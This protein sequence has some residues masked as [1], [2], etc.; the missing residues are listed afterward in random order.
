MTII[1]SLLLLGVAQG[2]LLG[3]VLWTTKRD[4][5][6]ANRMLGSVILIFSF[7]ILLHAL[8]HGRSS[9]DLKY[10]DSILHLGFLVI[11]PLLF[12][13]I[14]ALTAQS[15][16]WT[17]REFLHF[18]PVV[19]G[20]ALLALNMPFNFMNYQLLTELI[21]ASIGV[22]AVFY[23][24]LS[25]LRLRRHSQMI[26]NTFSSIEKINLRWIRFLLGMFC[27]AWIF[28]FAMEISKNE[29]FKIDLFWLFMSLFIYLMGYFGLRQPEIFTGISV[30]DQPLEPADKPKYE[31]ST[32]TFQKSEEY[33]Q[34]LQQLMKMEK[35]YIERDI[36]LPIL[37]EKMALTT[38][39]LSQIINE[40]LNKNFFEFINSYRIEEAKTMMAD[41]R[42]D[43]LSIA[44]LAYDAGFNSISAFN[45]A[46][47]KHVGVTPSQ[48]RQTCL[49]HL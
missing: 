3:I 27:L 13:Y 4:P 5:K 18:I 24:I 20:F 40:R 25:Y 1:Q 37:A 30:L 44:G 41:R 48:F 43:H 7:S 28:A 46:F 23:I 33:L 26:A 32:L 14:C 42:F 21:G 10:H 22:Q 17:R 45:A 38:H 39:E 35:P 34:R 16:Q 15:F 31:K 8:G 47:K 6:T 29:L 12:F 9:W 36:T 2:I 19:I 49:A 11:N